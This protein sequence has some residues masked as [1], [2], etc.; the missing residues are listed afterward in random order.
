MKS[1][2]DLERRNFLSLAAATNSWLPYAKTLLILH[3]DCTSKSG[4]TAVKL[5]AHLHP[6]C[7]ALLARQIWISCNTF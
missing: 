7:I 1:T 3:N 6:K 5:K 4:D 2:F